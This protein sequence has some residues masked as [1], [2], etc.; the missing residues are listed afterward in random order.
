MRRQVRVTAWDPTLIVWKEPKN[1]ELPHFHIVR[2][3]RWGR[4]I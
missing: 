4:V 3:K 2:C 1:L